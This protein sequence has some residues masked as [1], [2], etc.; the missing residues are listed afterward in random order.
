MSAP[1]ALLPFMLYITS[2]ILDIF[3]EFADGNLAFPIAFNEESFCILKIIG[4][5]N[6]VLQVICLVSDQT[7]TMYSTLLSVV[8]ATKSERR[9]L[10]IQDCHC[11]CIANYV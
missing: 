3:F 4:Q 1:A 2:V 10:R 9:A 8:I 6:I 5:W 7:T 11:Q